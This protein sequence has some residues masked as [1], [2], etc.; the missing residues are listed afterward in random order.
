MQLETLPLLL[1]SK[2]KFPIFNIIIK[3]VVIFI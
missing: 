3:I 2:K 1:I